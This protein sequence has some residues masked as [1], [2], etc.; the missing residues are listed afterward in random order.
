MSVRDKTHFEFADPAT[1]TRTRTRF[2]LLKPEATWLLDRRRSSFQLHVDGD[3]SPV[4]AQFRDVRRTVRFD[5]AHPEATV[6]GVELDIV[7]TG[8]KD[9][10]SPARRRLSESFRQEGEAISLVFWTRSVRVLGDGRFQVDGSVTIPGASQEIELQVM[11]TGKGLDR[12]GTRRV[13]YWAWARFTG[14]QF[15]PRWGSVLAA[16]QA[17]SAEVLD[18]VM[19]VELMENRAL[20]ASGPTQPET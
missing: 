8:R 7:P 19:E 1:G 6:I 20:G 12:D 13:H 17:K 5:D 4:A 15:G 14:S 3:P 2:E 18:L 10:A 16:F 9:A 11:E